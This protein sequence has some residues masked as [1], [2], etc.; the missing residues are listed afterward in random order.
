[1]HE[2]AE[3]DPEK[4]AE[5][6]VV[7]ETMKYATLGEDPEIDAG[8]NKLDRVDDTIKSGAVE[9]EVEGAAEQL[10]FPLLDLLGFITATAPKF[11]WTV[12]VLPSAP[13]FPANAE[14][15]LCVEI[16]A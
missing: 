11:I 5:Q 9:I 14:Y 3:G 6:D 12:E 1:M 15:L 7:G 16:G 8:I 10:L 13:T 4:T 2:E